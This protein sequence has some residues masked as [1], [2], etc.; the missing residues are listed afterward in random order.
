MKRRN[1]LKSIGI[2]AG[3]AVIAPKKLVPERIP[4]FENALSEEFTKLNTK[5]FQFGPDK[6]WARDQDVCICE[7]GWAYICHEYYTMKDR[8]FITGKERV[9]VRMTNSGKFMKTYKEFETEKYFAVVNT[10]GQPRD[11]TDIAYA[12]ARSNGRSDL[13]AQKQI[14]EI[15]NHIKSLNA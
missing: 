11:W 10:L 6:G 8:R 9:M 13:H 5:I 3:V 15:F 4:R 12:K 7:D 2:A 14:A 1:F